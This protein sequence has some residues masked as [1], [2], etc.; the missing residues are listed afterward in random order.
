MYKAIVI[1]DSFEVAEYLKQIFIDTGK[2]D[3]A[4]VLTDG[5]ETVK[6][7]EDIRPE[8][9][10]LDI[11][12][13]DESGIDIARSISKLSN[14]PEIIF[15][16]SYD[17]YALDAFKV[18]A[19]DYLVKPLKK[20]EI[21]RIINKL[22]LRLGLANKEKIAN[23]RLRVKALGGIDIR[24]GENNKKLKFPTAKAEELFLYL[25]FYNVNMHSKWHLIDILWPDKDE[26]K[27]ETNL[28]T[29]VYRINQA[30]NDNRIELKIKSDGGFYGLDIEGIEVDAFD[31]EKLNSNDY[32]QS[33][34]KEKVVDNIKKMYSGHLFEGYDFQWGIGLKSYYEN[35]FVNRILKYIDKLTNDEYDRYL[36]MEII[37]YLFEIS[38][39]NEDIIIR[40]IISLY[41]TSG[42]NQ[43]N[44]FYKKIVEKYSKEIGVKPSIEVTNIIEKLNM[45]K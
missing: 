30:F 18:N 23:G 4:L 45:K 2:F 24:F 27:G 6:A 8:V 39:Y 38:P 31:L 12:M 40:N 37:N 14:P 11:N 9:I 7:L 17:N 41:E 42:I 16:T 20:E 25:I 22:D 29:T 44:I 10:F 33:F 19:F 34:N 1:D 35:F 28:R 15:V 3:V 43:V 21:L 26:D 13:P 32:L 5:R 36:K